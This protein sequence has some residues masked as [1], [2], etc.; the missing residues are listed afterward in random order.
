MQSPN[1]YSNVGVDITAVV[2]PGVA[3]VYSLTCSNANAAS[4]FLQLHN[5]T[6]APTAG[7]VPAESFLV[8]AGATIIVGTDYFTNNGLNFSVGL[9]FAF[10]TTRD[11]Y[12]AGVA[13]DQQTHINYT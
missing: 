11:T 10:S 6:T 12:T 9:A 4:R 5:L 8:P 13:A 3:T 1:R 7:L 2:R